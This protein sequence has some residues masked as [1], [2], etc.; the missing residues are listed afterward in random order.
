VEP[1]VEPILLPS[2]VRFVGQGTQV[3]GDPGA[4]TFEAGHDFTSYAGPE[5]ARARVRRV[6]GERDVVTPEMR[7]DV[8]PSRPDHGANAVAVDR[9][10]RSEAG[11]ARAPQKA[12]DDGLGAVVGV[13]TGRDALDSHVRCRGA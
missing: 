12:H 4:Q 11:E 10:K 5:K 13:V 2:A 3:F 9:G 7:L 1:R 8:G 6:D